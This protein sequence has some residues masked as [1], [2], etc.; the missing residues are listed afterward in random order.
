MV[1]SDNREAVLRGIEIHEKAETFQEW[2]GKHKPYNYQLEWYQ[3]LANKTISNDAPIKIIMSRNQGRRYIRDF[4]NYIFEHIQTQK[5]LNE[6]LD[7]SKELL[8]LNICPH[9]LKKY[10]RCDNFEQC[11]LKPKGEAF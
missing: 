9:C 6:M 3:K 5:A 1:N 7:E 8:R 2:Y 10:E 4:E 11:K